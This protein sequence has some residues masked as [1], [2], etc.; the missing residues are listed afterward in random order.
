MRAIILSL[1][2]VVVACGGERV[3]AS[4]TPEEFI[5]ATPTVGAVVEREF[6]GQVRA[7]RHVELRARARGVVEAA[8]VDEGQRVKAGQLLF[9]LGTRAVQQELER[10]RATVASAVAELR[11]AQIAHDNT[12]MLFDRQVVSNAELE[13]ASAQVAALEARLREARAEEGHAEVNLSFGAV[14]APFDGVINRLPRRVGSLVAEDELLTTLA[15]TS[16]MHVYFQVSE[17]EYL[18][19]SRRPQGM[20]AGVTLKL[21]DG[22]VHPHAGS[23]DAVESEF[24]RATGNIAFRA[25]FPN[26][27][28]LLRHGASGKVVLRE[29][30]DDAIVVPQQSTFE[31]QEHLF[32]FT[33]DDEDIVHATRLM[34][35]A[36]LAD[37][38]V[39]ESGLAAGDRFVVE[40]AQRLRHG[41]RIVA[42]PRVTGL[43][44]SR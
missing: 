35:R 34:P 38:F 1:S 17:Q 3:I 9:T 7:V 42:R 18:A 21:A 36:R 29:S 2:A 5:V 25:R 41:Q 13:L 31:V 22:S 27:D 10:A 39:V 19:L 8:H 4:T 40:G 12:R 32:V 43:A 6:V 33:V 15:D 20:G 37:T 24:D 11:A 28:G 16:E 14:R 26:P 23:I 44:S 30:L